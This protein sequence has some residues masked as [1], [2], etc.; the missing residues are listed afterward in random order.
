[1]EEQS[2]GITITDTTIEKTPRESLAEVF[3]FYYL[4]SEAKILT[5]P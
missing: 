5:V 3:L 4:A 1:M 2:M